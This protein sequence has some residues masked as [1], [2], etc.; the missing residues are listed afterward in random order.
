MSGWIWARLYELG[1]AL[2]LIAALL[3]PIYL[4]GIWTAVFP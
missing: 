1:A 3:V 4:F 2:V